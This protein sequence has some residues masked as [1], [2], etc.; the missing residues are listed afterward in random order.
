MIFYLLISTCS[1]FLPQELP[2]TQKK[3]VTSQVARLATRNFQH[4]APEWTKI[5]CG[6]CALMLQ[7]AGRSRPVR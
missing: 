4:G 6:M 3:R 5:V 2:E 1:G 7:K